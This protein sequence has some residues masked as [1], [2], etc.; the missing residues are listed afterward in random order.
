MILVIDIGNT[1]THFGIY[2]GDKLKTHWSILN[3]V[4]K[5]QSDIILLNLKNYTIYQCTISCVVPSL[6]DVFN[7]IILENFGFSPL[8]IEHSFI[9]IPI[10]YDNPSKLGIDRIVNAIAAIKLYSL[11]CIVIDFGTATTIDVIS[12]D[13]EFMGGVIAPGISVSM[14][15]LW[16]KTEKLPI[17]EITVP[18]SVIG[19]NTV[20]CMQSGIFYGFIGQINEIIRR[21]YKELGKSKIYCISTGGLSNIIS[22][23]FKYIKQIDPLLTLKGLKIL[24]DEYYNNNSL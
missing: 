10:Y 22:P 15:T 23:Y 18:R 19:R 6:R 16:T 13:C 2:K 4:I 1:N 3:S 9:K 11:P 5:K 21:I 7:K 24:T 8:F 20:D 12:E 17:I 14:E